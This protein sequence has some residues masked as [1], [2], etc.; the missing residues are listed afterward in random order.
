V[1]AGSREWG[2]GHADLI[3]DFYAALQS[4]APFPV[5]GEEAAKVV[6][7]ILS[8]YASHGQRIPVIG[9]D[10]AD[11]GTAAECGDGAAEIA[12]ECKDRL[13]KENTK[14]GG[15]SSSAGTGEWGACGAAVCGCA[16]PGEKKERCDR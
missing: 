15:G 14:D 11:A 12:A 10:A 9:E 16:A 6:R 1:S 2:R 5:D 13:E 8:V 3:R 4:G 7:L